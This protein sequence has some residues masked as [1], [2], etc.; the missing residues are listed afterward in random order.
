MLQVVPPNTIST[1]TL[2]TMANSLPLVF[3][4]SAIKPELKEPV[5]LMTPIMPP[6]NKDKDH[7]I[8]G[9]NG[10]VYHADGNIADAFR[11]VFHPLIGIRNG[12]RLFDGPSVKF[13]RS[14]LILSFSRLSSVAG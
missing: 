6:Q 4:A 14:I 13:F 5:L 3:R 10:A 9:F 11:F 8:G 7:N 1:E 12:N 2:K